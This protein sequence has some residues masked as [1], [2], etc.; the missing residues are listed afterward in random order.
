MTLLQKQ[1]KPT[2]LA[3][4][5]GFVIYEGPSA[6]D[7]APV[8][9]IITLSSNNAKT[10]NMIQSWIMRA[11]MLPTEAAKTG[12]DDSICGNCIHR[13]FNKGACYV[14]IGHAPL[15]IYKAYQRGAY[16]IYNDAIH[17]RYI[18]GR[19][20]RMGS[21]GDPAAIKHGVWSELLAHTASHTGYTHQINHKGFDPAFLNTCQVSAD[22]PKQALKYQ[23]MGAMTFRVAMAGDSLING[24]IQCKADT[25][26]ISCLDCKL[27]DGASQNVVIEVHGSRSKR[28]NTRLIETVGV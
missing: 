13:H 28:F 7:G 24:E 27:C 14:N 19:A 12:Q 4:V 23:S 10:G 25:H 16:P 9:A 2:K 21:Y 22:S 3:P 5:K 18:V 1:V 26:G 8:V 15:A 6:L 17:S 20:L 11:D